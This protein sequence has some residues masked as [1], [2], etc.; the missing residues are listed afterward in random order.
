M[1]LHCNCHCVFSRK[2]DIVDSIYFTV[3]VTWGM[4]MLR[5]VQHSESLVYDVIS[6]NS[7][8]PE[9]YCKGIKGVSYFCCNVNGDANA[10]MESEL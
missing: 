3:T 2:T 9:N 8:T 1:C 10:L 6:Q 5:T 7:T 4:L